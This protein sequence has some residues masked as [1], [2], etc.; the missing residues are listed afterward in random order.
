MAWLAFVESVLEDRPIGHKNMVSQHAQERW[1]LVTCSVALKCG[2]F[3][4]PGICG[5]SKHKLKSSSD[6]MNW[7]RANTMHVLAGDADDC[8]R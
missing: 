4:M 8:S 2:T 5:P 3:C 6:Y 7:V 1:S